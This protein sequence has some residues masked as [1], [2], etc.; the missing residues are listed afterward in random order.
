MGAGRRANTVCQSEDGL[1]HHL[2][3][4]Q[5]YHNFVVPHASLRQ[6]LPVAEPTNGTGS[7]KS[8]P[9]RLAQ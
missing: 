5:A 9:M 1:Q 8:D 6:P 4:F 2:A 3:V 7:A